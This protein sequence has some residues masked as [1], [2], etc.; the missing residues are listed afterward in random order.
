M[1]QLEKTITLLSHL[2]LFGEMSREE[3]E[4]I[5]QGTRELGLS[6]G[7]ILFNCG[8]AST[9]FYVL[10]YGQ[11]KLALTSPR[12]GEKVLELVGPGQSFG[13][14]LMFLDKPYPL[15]A[16]ALDDSLLLHISK[17]VI[18]GGIDTDPAFCRKMLAG[19]SIRLH[20]L[21]Q[22][23]ESIS[24]CTPEQRVVNYLLQ[25]LG[26][27]T[28]GRD[29]HIG[30]SARKNVIS[31]CLNITP[32]TLSRILHNLSVA[33]LIKVEG[34]DICIKDVARLRLAS[35]ENG[36]VNSQKG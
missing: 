34:Q 15:Y 12:G 6:R 32:E 31:S 23:V 14:A 35:R 8:D 1:N 11:I 26:D 33:G 5:A 17:N 18:V 27:I 29:V 2:P 7:E 20:R 36:L 22:N 30:L 21:I 3:I 28:E 10:I 13:E 24:L 25:H 16:Q 19:L 4:R 9:G